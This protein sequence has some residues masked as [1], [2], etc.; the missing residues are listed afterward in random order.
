MIINGNP[1]NT[2]QY[3]IEGQVAMEQSGLRLYTTIGQPSVDAIQEVAIQTS[4]YAAEFGTV[5]GGIF[6]VT[7][8]SGTN[9][10]HGSGYDYAAN[11]I[12]NADQPYT[13][14]RNPTRRHEFG[15]TFGGPAW[16]PKVS[17]GQNKTFYFIAWDQFRENLSV[18]PTATTVPIPA[19]RAGDFTQLWTGNNNQM[20]QVSTNRNYVDPQLRSFLSGTIFD[21][22]TEHPVT[23]VTG[24]PPAVGQPN[25]TNGSTVLVRDPFPGNKITDLSRFDTVS[26]NVLKLVP[27]PIGA[28]ADKGLVGN[29]FQKPWISQTRS[30]IPSIKFDQAVGGSHRLS[31]YYQET[32]QEVQYSQVNGNMEGLPDPISAERGSHIY[33]YTHRL[34][35]D[36]TV[37]P[38]LLLH[39]GIGW[40]YNDFDDHTA[41]TD[42]NALTAIGL[43]G[44]TLNRNFPVL[45][46]GCSITTCNATGG[47]NSLGPVFGQTVSG[48]R[49]P[50]S[51]SSLSWVKGNHTYKFGGEWRGERYPNS[52]YSGTAGNYTFGA[53][54]TQQTA[55][56]GV[57]ISQGQNGFNF[58]AFLLGDVS[59][60]SLTLPT[61]VQGAKSQWAAFVQDTWKITR[62]L[63][64]DY[65]LRWDLGTYGRESHGRNANFSR[66][67]LN[68]S[69]GGH[70]GGQIFEQTC[71]C[72]FANNYGL[73]LGPRVGFAYQL[74]TKTVM[75]G[76]FAIVY[77]GTTS[78]AG[79]ASASASSSNQ[80]FGQFVSQFQNGI[81]ADV[82]PRWPVFEPNVGQAAGAV[83]NGP[84]LL[85]GNAGRPA[86]Q[87]QW[88][89][90]VQREISR[91][92]VVEASYVANRGVWWVAGG[93]AP[94][95]VTSMDILS[96]YQFTIGSGDS[97]LLRL[98]MSGFNTTQLSGLAAHGVI[99]PYSNFPTSQTLRQSLLP[100]P[101]YTGTFS[102]TNAPLGKT[103]YD[104]LQ[105]NV[106]KR[107]SHGITLNANY[108]FSK[109]LDLMSSPDVFNRQLGKDISGNDLPHQLRISGEYQ[110]QNYSNRGIP[111]ISNKV[112]SFVIANWG[113]GFAMQYQSAAALLRPTSTSPN[114][115]N[116]YLGRGP[117]SAQVNLDAN[118]QPISPWSTDWTDYDGVHHTDPIDI[119]CHCF[120][121]TKTQV[122]NQ[123]LTDASKQSWKNIPDFQWADNFSTLRDFRGFRRPNENFN[124]SRNFRF[125][126]GRINLN[127]RVEFS[128]VF[129]RTLLPNPVT[130][131]QGITFSSKPNTF[132]SGP[133]TGLYSAGF[134]TILPTT[135][136]S[137]QRAGQFVSRLTF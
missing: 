77:N 20:I 19:Y 91:D 42:F 18:T 122:L 80:A 102:P 16:I 2:A 45:N 13:A 30:K 99:L 130:T 82:A 7:M 73:A 74:N 60:V 107:Y 109:N 81:P 37:R 50:S 57:T 58:A 12:L 98:P 97:N 104:S 3:R 14:I 84:A 52:G 53:N 87:Y 46:V 71:D 126:E 47:M 135:G 127:V 39:M 119:N 24:T 10:Y 54:G 134:G 44:A 133:N 48:E 11:D 33:T 96:R 93:L 101:Q 103:W 88:S 100:F 51:V 23:C 78:V 43:K 31:Y 129:N 114:S 94:V 59:S 22:K 61:A 55:L 56:D 27:L 69:A 85:D 137:G 67:I 9:Q 131:G 28:N 29:N 68:P 83:V 4:T 17:N 76:G 111:V 1:Q 117:G 41:V 79:S 116:N 124:V 95:N 136:T 62:K 38:T 90:G 5:G 26:Q 112:V 49:R 106:T 75:R 65:G 105:I 72:H 64:F 36:Y 118:G 40:Y 132:P 35:W 123:N 6:N 63:T 115:I 92:L 8:K 25:C 128:N 34:N 110:T 70:P 89:F 21:S 66:T 113:L 108:A 120:D 86:R 15:F 32:G 121:P 125:K